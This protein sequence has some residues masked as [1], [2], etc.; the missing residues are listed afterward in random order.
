MTTQPIPTAGR[1]LRRLARSVFGYKSLREGQEEAIRSVLARHD[2]LAVMPTG[3]GKSAVYQLAGMALDGP[4]LVISPLIALQQDQVSALDEHA[5][6]TG[7]AALLN[8]TLSA[9]AREETMRAFETGE[10]EFLFLAPEQLANEETVARLRAAKP[11]LFVVDEAHC[12]SE[13]GFDFRPEYL[14]LGSAVEA[15]GRPVVLALTATAAPPVRAEIV[16]RLGMREP[17]VIVSGFDRPNLELCVS[18]YEDDGTRRADLLDY[19]ARSAKPGLVYASTRRKSEEI[20]EALCARGLRAR[21]YHAGMKPQE[22]EETQVAFMDDELEVVVAT[23]AFGMGIDKPNVRFVAH[24]D[25]PGSVDAYYQ[26]V[27]RAGRDG[28][29]AEVHLFFCERDLRLRRFFAQSTPMEADDLERVL[30][31]LEIAGRAVTTKALAQETGLAQTKFL[32]AL[33]RLEEVGAIEM[34]RGGRVKLCRTVS[35]DALTDAASEAASHQE[36]RREYE[37]SRLEMMRGYA[38]TAGCRREYLLSYFG[39]AFDPPCGRCDNCR[40]GRVSARDED[41]PFRVGERVRH[42]GFGDGQVVRLE[43]GKVT[44]LFDERGYQTLAL[45]VVLENGL[46]EEAE[47]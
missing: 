47:G 23:T 14:R 11:S 42:P 22:R 12:V 6:D 25:L 3:S 32:A 17:N 43:E 21:A 28:E 41:A 38:T 13:W 10:L 16:E 27:G 2:T 18:S 19:V 46:L 4:T 36:H 29:D 34:T 24:A 45:A 7:R 26:E 33:S 5:E 44:V 9:A 39:E 37:R 8:S 1:Q 20:A 31:L 15:L 30:R 35:G 40:A